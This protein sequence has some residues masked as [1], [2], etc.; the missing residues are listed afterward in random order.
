MQKSCKGLKFTGHLLPAIVWGV[1]I[2]IVLSI[3]DSTIPKVRLLDITHIDKV[4]HFVLFFV[5]SL[6]LC[7]GFFRQNL[8]RSL[9]NHYMVYAISISI[10]YGGATEVLQAIWFVSR[11]GNVWDFFANTAGAIT[12]AIVFYRIF[13]N[14]LLKIPNKSKLL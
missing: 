6:L 10:I 7:Y 5:F 13:K 9:Q 8:V 1:G 3:P 14:K 11:S 4:I 2:F 12:G